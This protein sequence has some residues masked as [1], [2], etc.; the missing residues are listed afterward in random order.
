MKTSLFVFLFIASCAITQNMIPN[1][2]FEQVKGCPGAF[3][4]LDN[5]EHWFRLD[6]HNGTPDQFYGDCGYNGI[7]NAMAPGQKPYEGV[8]YAGGFCHGDNLRE[9]MV[10]QTETPLLKDSL[11]NLTF[12]VLPAAG[13]GTMINSYGAHFSVDRPNGNATLNTMQFEE[14]V[15]NPSDRIIEDLVS[16]TK[17][18]GVYKAKGG[19]QYITF[20]NFKTD[21][22]TGSRRVLENSI[23]PDRSYMLIDGV[24]C[25]P[26]F[27]MKPDE[28]VQTT[29]RT[30]LLSDFKDRTE[31][32]KSEYRT[33][34]KEIS[35]KFWDH[36]QDDGDSI[37]VFFD[38]SLLVH[39][40]R[41][42]KAGLQLKINTLPGEHKIRLIAVN[43]GEIPP[44]T[45]SITISDRRNKKTF[46]LNSDLESTEY[47]SL[48]ILP[49][50]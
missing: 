37:I 35:I 14:H 9:Y 23:R 18:S 2:G 36:L 30:I 46:I 34:S 26:T 29:H 41:I 27:Q 7:I 13:Y 42:S 1:P 40:Y 12:Y 10:I 20:G 25:S 19:E 22:Q 38:D 31:V 50:E 21:A 49:D 17:I 44:N 47:L 5:T 24:E 39:N 28:L 3:V 16:W 4:F 8:G 32:R 43:L 6:N 48:I 11:Y 45:C 15:G 33:K